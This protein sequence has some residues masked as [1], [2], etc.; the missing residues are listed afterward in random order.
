[1]KIKYKITEKG[2]CE[3]DCPFGAMTVV[4][5]GCYGKEYVIKVGS[6]VC[7]GCDF[8]QFNDTEK[9]IVTCKKGE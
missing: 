5:P 9:K 8:C 7:D 6:W 3:T 4:E 2:L 1:M